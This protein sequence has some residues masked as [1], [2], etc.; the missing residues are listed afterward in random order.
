MWSILV[1]VPCVTEKNVYSAVV[2]S[3]CWKSVYSAVEVVSSIRL[4][5]SVVGFGYVLSDLCPLD[6]PYPWRGVEVSNYDSGFIH[7]SLQ[8]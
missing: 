8:L 5:D 7:L 2:G 3:Q 1:N 6:V 4:I